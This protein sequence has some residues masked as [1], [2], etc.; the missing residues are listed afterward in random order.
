MCKVE[1]QLSQHAEPGRALPQIQTMSINELAYRT[2]TLTVAGKRKFDEDV[3]EAVE[4]VS[5]AKGWV[6]HVIDDIST[7]RL[8]LILAFIANEGGVTPPPSKE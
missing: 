4:A 8:E 2:L 7:K 6:N 5:L 1:S 3:V